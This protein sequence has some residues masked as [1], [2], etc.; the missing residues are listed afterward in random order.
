MINPRAIATEGLDYGSRFIALEGL[1][2]Y[3]QIS[4]LSIRGKRVAAKMPFY[5]RQAAPR[6]NF[7]NFGNLGNS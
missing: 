6:F 5:L 4:I 2:L 7:G 1:V 3:V